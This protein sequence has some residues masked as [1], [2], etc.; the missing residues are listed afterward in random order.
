M[1]PNLIKI[2]LVFIILFS[3]ITF[4]ENIEINPKEVL[5]EIGHEEYTVFTV[6]NVGNNDI[7]NLRINIEGKFPD[8]FKLENDRIDAI[9]KGEEA[10]FS[11]KTFVNDTE[12]G[13][14]GFYINISNSVS[15][16]KNFSVRL[17]ANKFDRLLYEIQ[18]LRGE[19]KA[20]EEKILKAEADGKDVSSVTNMTEETGLMLDSAEGYVYTKNYDKAI[21]LMRNIEDN[22]RKIDSEISLAQFKWFNFFINFGF[23]GLFILILLMIAFYNM[24]SIYRSLKE[25]NIEKI[26]QTKEMKTKRIKELEKAEETLDEELKQ[27]LITK[28]KYEELKKK[29]ENMIE[30]AEKEK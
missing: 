23:M 20:S 16:V 24:T 14:Y 9:K 21:E 13:V 29:Y 22:I 11:I 1:Q 25:K 5:V 6:K 18:S 15:D 7:Y 8:W 19:L 4:A 3:T 17:F 10:S 12:P 26:S 30:K 28:E 2:T 27:G